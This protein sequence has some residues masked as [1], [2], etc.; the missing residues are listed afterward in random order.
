MNDA[1]STNGGATAPASAYS[2]SPMLIVCP[3]CASEYDIDAAKLGPAGRTVRCA[4]CRTKFHVAPPEESWDEPDPEPVEPPQEADAS[5]YGPVSTAEIDDG[6]P[7]LSVDAAASRAD[8]PAPGRKKRKPAAKPAKTKSRS[9]ATFGRAAAV[10]ASL[11]ALAGLF[12]AR[13]TI[14]SRVPDTAA[15]YA[16]VGFRVNLRGLDF[17]DVRSTVSGEG[18]EATLIIEGEIKN[19]TGKNVDIPSLAFA[20]SGPDGIPLYTW[21][22]EPPR[23]SL[24]PGETTRFRSRLAAPPPESRQVLVRFAPAAEGT[25]IARGR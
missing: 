3:S 24:G 2:D 5:P 18:R 8:A 12:V 19:P 9:T 10:A 4:S 11:A 13:E 25:S 16:A 21:G 1:Q 20:V 6:P 23:Q 14:V 15:L 17:A 22:T 7:A